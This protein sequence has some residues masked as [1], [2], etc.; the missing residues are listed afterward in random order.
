LRLPLSSSAGLGERTCVRFNIRRLS[1][2]EATSLFICQLWRMRARTCV[3]SNV[4]RLSVFGAAS[5]FI[6]QL[7]RM[8]ARTHVC[9]F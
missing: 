6:C 9:A 3:R 4:R 8:R 5:L 7:W 1:A 2:F